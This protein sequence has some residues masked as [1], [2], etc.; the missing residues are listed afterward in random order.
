MDP[1]SKGLQKVFCT[2]QNCF[3][4][5]AKWGLGWCKRLFGDLCSLGPKDLLHPP[6]STFGNLPFSVNLPGPQLPKVRPFF[7]GDDSIW[8]C[9]SSL[10]SALT[11]FGSPESY[12]SLAIIGFRA[13][14][15]IVPEYYDRLG[16]MKSKE[17]RLLI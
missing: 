5:G 14:E 17:S 13:F 1:R 6:L 3:C 9:P 15:L 2:T 16:K 12:F 4:T 7:L 10:P 11:A 8:N